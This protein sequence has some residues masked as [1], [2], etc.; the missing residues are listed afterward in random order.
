MQDEFTD[1]IIEN[2]PIRETV[3]RISKVKKETD[4][5]FDTKEVIPKDS[6]LKK[7]QGLNQRNKRNY[8]DINIYYSI[9]IISSRI[10]FGSRSLLD[11]D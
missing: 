2:F 4:D 5:V 11:I 6:S 1:I 10:F 8:K 9:F 7:N 3:A